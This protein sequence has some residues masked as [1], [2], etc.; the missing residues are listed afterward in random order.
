[1]DEKKKNELYQEY[2]KKGRAICLKYQE[3]AE[4]VYKK[5]KVNGHTIRD[6][7]VPEENVIRKKEKEEIKK[8]AAIYRAKCNE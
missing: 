4:V 7:S 1:M 5:N 2:L 3:A 6:A 8:L